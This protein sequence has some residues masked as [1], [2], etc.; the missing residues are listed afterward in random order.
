MLFQDLLQITLRNHRALCPL[1]DK[2][3]ENDL[4]YTWSLPFPLIVTKAGKQHVLRTP[5]DL[6]GFYESLNL[7]PI[8]LLEWYQEFALPRAEESPNRPPLS[9]PEKRSSK[10]MKHN[11]NASSHR[12]TPN[13]RSTSSRALDEDQMGAHSW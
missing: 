2:L 5:P 6:S 11:R 9:Y 3:R 8:A 12:G 10:K 1:L 4:K 7:D 13:P